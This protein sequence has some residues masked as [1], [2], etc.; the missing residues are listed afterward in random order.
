[1]KE[2]EELKEYMK[3]HFKIFEDLN[4]YMWAASGCVRDFFVG[5]APNDY[6]FYFTK[7]E[8]RAKAEVK[9]LELNAIKISS[10][11]FGNKFSYNDFEYD[12]MCWDGN[13]KANRTAR[14]PRDMIDLFE[15]TVE[16][17]AIDN[18]GVFYSHP[19]FL[20]DVR[21]KKLIR[22]STRDLFPRH[23]NRRLLKYIKN[24]FT[25]DDKN[26][27]AWLEDQEATFK[28]RRQINN[29]KNT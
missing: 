12:L 21:N 3:P 28:Y 7:E 17:G 22:N 20:E 4:V 29:Q 6:D 11:P 8:D 13:N 19:T 16:M 18:E 23:N 2:V 1:M 14:G 9:I 25:I 5:K 27:L 10:T 26:L 15:W 24:E